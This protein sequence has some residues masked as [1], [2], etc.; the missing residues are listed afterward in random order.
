MAKAIVPVVVKMF[1]EADGSLEGAIKSV[2]GTIQQAAKSS[3][4]SVSLST[5]TIVKTVSDKATRALSDAKISFIS[6]RDLAS[7]RTG[8]S[9]IQSNAD[10]L[11]NSLFKL[12]DRFF[13]ISKASSDIRTIKPFDAAVDKAEQLDKVY[14]QLTVALQFQKRSAE[15]L[16]KA[17]QPDLVR[18]RQQLDDAKLLVKE[19]QSQAAQIQK[20]FQSAYNESAK[21][22]KALQ[23]ELNK[24]PDTSGPVQGPQLNPQ[25]EVAASLELSLL[26]QANNV[27]RQAIQL[28][29]LNNRITEDRLTLERRISDVTKDADRQKLQAGQS[30]LRNLANEASLAR[31]NALNA[32][33][34]FEQN[35]QNQLK[36]A[37]ANSP[38]S[39]R[40][41]LISEQSRITAANLERDAKKAESAYTSAFN[42]IQK[43]ADKALGT[44]TRS[45]Q[46][47]SA[48]RVSAGLGIFSPLANQLSSTIDSLIGSITGS[49]AIFRTTAGVQIGQAISQG[50]GQGITNGADFA[51]SGIDD[52]ITSFSKL[53]NP[54]KQLIANI[55]TGIT[56]AAAA[57]GAALG[58]LAGV[59]TKTAAGFEVQVA[60][61]TT[62]FKDPT[63]AV[64]RFQEALELAAKTPYNVEQVVQAQVQLSALGQKN[65]DILRDTVDLASGLN[66]DLARTANEVGKAAAGSLRGYQELR[67]T[68]G[69]T[70]ERLKQFGAVVDSQN[71]LMVTNE[72]QIR[73]NREAL[74]ALIRTDFGGSSER[75]SR[76]LEGQISNLQDEIIKL[77]GAIG[78]AY[79]P[80]AKGAVQVTREFFEY[81]NS[82]PQSFKTFA[83]GLIGTGAAVGIMTAGLAATSLA[84]S[85]LGST[86]A[87]FSAG[88]LA[89]FITRIPLASAAVGFFDIVLN[90]VAVKSI[91]LLG[92]SLA[93]AAGPLALLVT[94]A[95]LLNTAFV[96]QQQEAEKTSE[97]IK[98]YSREVANARRV[99]IEF[100]EDLVRVFQFPKD[101][102][103]DTDDA[104]T[105][106]QKLDKEFKSR[107]ALSV[108]QDL[109][110]AGISLDSVTEKYV[111]QSKQLDIQRNKIKGLQE[112]QAL[113]QEQVVKTNTSLGQIDRTAPVGTGN[114]IGVIQQ[115]E[116]ANPSLAVFTRGLLEL[117]GTSQDTFDQL[118]KFGAVLQ[119]NVNKLGPAVAEYKLLTDNI[120]AVRDA[121]DKVQK[122]LAKLEAPAKFAL[123]IGDLNLINDSLKDQEALLE[124]INSQ[125]NTSGL[126]PANAKTAFS[127]EEATKLL[128][129]ASDANKILLEGFIKTNETITEL[130]N[131]RY[132]AQA[133]Q[134]KIRLQAIEAQEKSEL[135]VL[136]KSDKEKQLKIIRSAE[137][138]VKAR[139][140]MYLRDIK[141]YTEVQDALN[142]EQD[143]G[144]RFRLQNLLDRNKER[145]KAEKEAFD[146]YIDQKK[147][148]NT[149]EAE[150]DQEKYKKLKQQLETFLADT[151]Q[152]INGVAPSEPQT[153]T[154]LG[155]D[156]KEITVV[157]NSV[158]KL[159]DDIE[160]RPLSAAEK[161]KVLN[162]RLTELRNLQKTTNFASLGAASDDAKKSFRDNEREI[163]NAIAKAKLEAARANIKNEKTGQKESFKDFTLGV[164]KD[165]S[166]AIN[167]SD[168]LKVLQDALAKLKSDEVKSHIKV[169]DY[170]AEEAKLTRQIN[171]IQADLTKQIKDQVKDLEKIRQTR[172]K[173][174]IEILEI[175]K[176]NASGAEKE[177]IESQ[178]KGRRKQQIQA[179]FQELKAERDAELAEATKNGKNK[180]LILDKYAAKEQELIRKAYLE[181]KKAEDDKLKATLDRFKAEDD[182]LNGFKQNRLG[183]ANSPIISL[184]ELSFRST[185]S[186]FGSSADSRADR[187]K[188]NF[189]TPGGRGKVPSFESFRLKFEQENNLKLGKDGQP[190]PS[191][192]DDLKPIPQPAGTQVTA[193]VI[194]DG[195]NVAEQE[196]AKDAAKL[197]KK[198]LVA[199]N[200]KVKL[201]SGNDAQDLDSPPSGGLDLSFSF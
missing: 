165:L 200:K 77:S 189:A 175:R 190:L 174:E 71:R 30:N 141:T 61:L 87:A 85:V 76:T 171:D 1:A 12:Q 48:G 36:A 68:L 140:D 185:L 105:V 194:I 199:A 38:D 180:E 114:L 192:Y 143:A 11:Q 148:E 136:T 159:F 69:I 120:A 10:Q 106:L 168:K 49:S 186:G 163:E 115:F 187:L 65:I 179:E 178:L 66:A 145:I 21:S 147:K 100:K 20:S 112:L 42:T 151:K 177:A 99:N 40:L 63:L 80:S 81:L 7:A 25:R 64:E 107:G 169:N 150:L 59:M 110:L 118:D 37:Q 47:A 173:D 82:L 89:A 5:E 14:R 97:L 93:T 28:N 184:E 197:V 86:A 119:G 29:Q 101:F 32:Q 128:S 8:L 176:N 156:G 155:I 73:K 18:A 160:A 149:I 181:H 67:N 133:E 9:A 35:T 74:L 122:P 121:L 138:I 53:D 75:L 198:S 125:I 15:E 96:N 152:V 131:K 146:F 95:G 16:A 188:D 91:P 70:Q 123:K 39:K 127:I 72:F 24:K 55:G 129:G 111:E 142:T 126:R 195:A 166:E 52:L 51:K 161:L 90:T 56:V 79:I 62:T 45:S 132:A 6:E 46:Q 3:L 58:G 57:A 108:V 154:F 4:Q 60:K 139:A 78:S 34:V 183:G 157:N 167:K 113:L 13:Q 191:P 103:K 170:R 158:N 19:L 83:A 182:A 50:I 164:D 88:P 172:L 44:V 109:E 201:L 41:K 135:S 116:Q 23:A 26:Q 153:R 134:D 17:P 33:R 94:A 98:G 84:L 117:K 102:I 2:A 144:E 54:S 130:S 43:A 124:K 104:A 22:L 196:V 27:K 31:Q 92:T 193:T 162:T 137:A